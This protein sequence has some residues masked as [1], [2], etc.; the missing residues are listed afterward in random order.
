LKMRTLFTWLAAV[1]LLLLAFPMRGS[2]NALAAPPVPKVLP[3]H[4]PDAVALGKAVLRGHHRGDDILHLAIGLTLRDKPALDQFL[5]Q[6]ND[7]SS[8]GYHQYLSQDEANRAFNPTARQ[9]Q[10]VVKWLQANGLTVTTTYPNHLMVDAQGTTVQVERLFRVTINDFH[11]RVRGKETDFYAPINNPVVDGTVSDFVDSVIGLDNYPRF[12][13]QS[14]GAAHG[15]APYYP[16]DF[17]NA[18]DVNPLLNA[19][20]NGAGQHIGITLWTVPPSDATLQHFGSITGAAVATT[21]NG[22]LHV[23]P[24]D[25]G[26]NGTVSPDAGEAG[27]DIESSGGIAPGATIDYYEAPTDTSGNPTDQGLEDALNQAGT[28]SNVN[29]QITNSWGGCEASST[30]DAFASATN[31]I[32]SSNSSTGHNYFFSS[33]DNGSWCAPNGV[34]GTDPY[35][36][37]PT[38][39][40]YVTSVGGTA[41]SGNIGSGY[42]GETTWAYCSTCN[43][44]NPEG[45]GGGY[46]N[47][48]SRPSWQTGSGLAANGKRGYPDLAADADPN[49]GAEVC[50]GASSTCGQIGGTS[51][52]SPLW[53]GMLA[54]INQYLNAQGKPYAGFFD[55][56]I[57]SLATHA[58]TYPPFHDV[59]SGTNGAYNAG[60]SWDAVTGWGSA[61]VY[62]LARDMAGSGGT[63]STPTPTPV[64]PTATPTSVP[65][66][67]TPTSAPP[68]AT[69]TSAPPTATPTSKPGPTST[70]A[71][72]STAKPTATSTPKP[73][74]TPVPVS[75]QLIV[76]GGFESGQT[77][78]QESSTGGYQIVDPTRPHTGTNSAYLCG[79]NNC[80]DQIYQTVTL[81]A[82]FSKVTLGYWYYSDTQEAAGSPCYDYFYSRLQTSSGG[83]ITTPQQSCNSS[84]TN[85]WVYKSFDLSTAL[86]SYNGQAVRVYFQGTTDTSLIS[87]FFVDDVTLTVS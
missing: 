14:N 29:R 28:D 65:P 10:E 37:Y 58:Q 13:I 68:T 55:P 3:G 44:G 36:D 81:P 73:T 19:G 62:N 2:I 64:P 22:K 23:I 4:V 63:S 70:P 52:A 31:N 67:A 5:A 26:A 41:F 12:F 56:T 83:T 38:S 45:S 30:G 78:W 8:P 57:Y 84:V 16:Q 61:D 66:T 47:I 7:P 6:V 39:S 24:V 76:N 43:A 53:A 35:P 32:F 33:G 85:G 20:Y 17:I 42:P 49:T 54:I 75:K 48:W 71:P 34:T 69:P 60:A 79:Y 9:E 40:P 80:N 18:Y 27:M 82:S 51:L 1:A 74:A 11:H 59:T 50:Y 77:P 87:D 86:S 15:A 72:T 46:S 25:G 21:A